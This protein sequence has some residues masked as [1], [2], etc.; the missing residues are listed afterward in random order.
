MS[1]WE[2]R[3][4]YFALLIMVILAV[5]VA[6]PTGTDGAVP[7]DV[8]L[9]TG[10]VT[11]SNEDPIEGAFI[12]V[13]NAFGGSNLTG[14]NETG[15]FM[16]NVSFDGFATIEVSMPGYLSARSYLILTYGTE[17]MVDIVLETLPAATED[18]SGHVSFE[19]GSDAE[20]VIVLMVYDGMDGFY[21]Y[22]DLTDPSGDFSFSLFPG[23]YGI[24]MAYKGLSVLEDYMFIEEG[25]GPYDYDAD[26]PM[27][28][29]LDSAVEG[30]VSD[31]S[32]PMPGVSVT[33]LD[34]DNFIMQRAVTDETGHYRIPFYSGDHRFS[35]EMDDYE[36]VDQVHLDGGTVWINHTA[37]SMDN[38]ISGTV[39]NETGAPVAEADV[40]LYLPHIS[41]YN[42]GETDEDGA[43]SFMAPDGEGY[44]VAQV[45]YW[46]EI[47]NGYYVES[48]SVGESDKY[49]EEVD[50]TG[51]I[52][53]DIT[54]TNDDVTLQ[55]FNLTFDPWGELS[56]DLTL[57]VSRT[58]VFGMRMMIDEWMGNSDLEVS[59]AEAAIWEA[60]EEAMLAEGPWGIVTKDNITLDGVDYTAGPYVYEMN[61]YEGAW[62]DP[63][64]IY[65]SYQVDYTLNGAV[66]DI[67]PHMLMVNV[68]LDYEG[69][70]SIVN[71]LIPEGWT[72]YESVSENSTATGIDNR[73]IISPGIEPWDAEDE[74]DP[75]MMTLYPDELGVT[76][77]I[78]DPIYEG[79][80]YN[81]TWVV[82]DAFPE[83][84]Y[85]VTL[86]FGDGDM[87]ENAEDKVPH[88]Y[89]DN[90]TYDFNV[91]VTDGIGRSVHYAT[92][93][94]VLNSAPTIVIFATGL[95][96]GTSLEGDMV[97]VTVNASDVP[98]DLL[99]IAWSLNGTYDYFYN[100]TSLAT[101]DYTVPDEGSYTVFAMVRDDDS[102]W[103]EA[104]LT[105]VAEN[106][107]P[108]VSV[109]MT[110]P[111]ADGKVLEG[112]SVSVKVAA[113]DPSDALVVDIAVTGGS[114][115]KVRTVSAG[116]EYLVQL[117][118]TGSYDIKVTVSD[119][120]GGIVE[121]TESFTV[122]VNET[123]DHD[124][125]GIPMKW[126]KDNGLNDSDAADAGKDPDGDGLTNLQEYQRNSDPQDKNSPVKQKD[127]KKTDLTLLWI[128][129]A[130]IAILVVIA[131]FIL[132]QRKGKKEK[133]E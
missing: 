113:T 74:Y 119:G 45:T 60:F 128:V 104:N 50:I 27:I 116:E 112:E 62:N 18:L 96:N 122:D 133:E 58:D 91:S 31:D 11:D 101:F 99:E 52:E 121:R 114:D 94:T 80:S 85:D 130:V 123:L 21:S 90:G 4:K 36:Y 55:N 115:Y 118:A 3:L 65:G 108:T 41:L 26:I 42:T 8:C 125:D 79:T 28:P 61:G 92:T 22:S 57:E 109:K 54:L 84:T 131:V 33:V 29:D 53:R 66:E 46:V 2:L 10:T 32:G 69:I 35:I 126:E 89:A 44:L 71:I 87:I 77:A 97:R 64:P 56:V 75:V 70:E 39:A 51:D 47:D 23:F 102:A 12:L 72:L 68:S 107:V 25:G 5:P 16:L 105:F 1:A 24:H 14:S 132:M 63:A 93:I 38:E 30:Y 43:F 88:A 120:D 124:G 13:K 9:I 17:S 86:D 6:M 129:I 19:G 20:G 76:A 103:S 106:V 40:E 127:D 34:M 81:F 37:L 117:N 110:A 49:I 83:N 98:A 95:D 59:S 82:T 15:H 111:R 100:I 67:E 73:I 48:Y 78:P 7:D